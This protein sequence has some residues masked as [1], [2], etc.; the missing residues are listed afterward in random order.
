MTVS[1]SYAPLTYAGNDATTA[2]SV[3]WPF[4]TGTLVVTLI[5]DSTGVETVKSLTTHYTVSGGTGSTG[6]PAT[7]TVTMLTAPATGETLRIERSTARTQASTWAENDAFPQATVEAMADKAILIAQEADYV[8]NRA[9]KQ[10]VAEYGTNG[11]LALPE[12]SASSYLGWNAGGTALENKDGAE[13]T[14]T[15]G[16]VTT[17][18]A[19]TSASA[20]ITGTAEAGVLNLTIPRGDAG[21]SGAGT[22]DVVGPVSATANAI[23]LFDG[24]SGT[25]IKDSTYT[26]TAA[27]AALLDDAAASNQR[28]TLGLAIGTDVQ[29][30]D[31]DLAAI[32]GLTLAQGDILY[33]NASQV[34]NLAAGTA[35]YLLTTGGAG[36]NPAWA[37]PWSIAGLTAETA[38]AVADTVAIYDASAAAEREMTLAN[39]LTVINLLTEDTSPDTASDFVLSYDTS[40]SAVKKVKP[41]NLAAGAWDLIGSTTVGA[42]VASIEHTWTADDYSAVRVV[43]SGLS[44]STTASLTVSLRHSGASILDLGSKSVNSTT[45]IDGAA[46]TFTYVDPTDDTLTFA[47]SDILTG[48]CDFA[49]DVNSATKF[50]TGVGI[51][52]GGA[53]GAALGRGTSGSS[54]TAPDRARVAFSAGNIDAG[55]VFVYGMKVV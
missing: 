53:L 31:A 47:A 5:V 55:Q 45:T 21:A 49:I 51:I 42:A 44:P 37:A 33:R 29:A 18:A 20:T 14:I 46:A 15:I 22:G 17:G 16:T 25:L 19:G 40:A 24:T 6:L 36:A 48:M 9:I 41:E 38:P 23:A 27:G 54:A 52:N 32:S 10:T 50:H 39:L 1:T 11:A 12:A 13:Y 26:I 35:G 28:T 2:F 34:T 4:F 30:Y 8:A 43:L 3:T 7:G